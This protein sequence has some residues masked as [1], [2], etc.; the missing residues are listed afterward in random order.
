MFYKHSFLVIIAKGGILLQT[1]ISLLPLYILVF[2]LNCICFCEIN[3][4]DFQTLVMLSGINV[5]NF[6]T[7]FS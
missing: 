4:H 6:F 5:Y 3:F 1:L 7:H 2:Y